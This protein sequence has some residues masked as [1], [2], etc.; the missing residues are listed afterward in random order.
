MFI[1]KTILR[2]IPLS[3]YDV[4]RKAA[5][6]PKAINIGFSEVNVTGKC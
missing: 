3:E 2:I 5:I 1:K 4:Q 6:L